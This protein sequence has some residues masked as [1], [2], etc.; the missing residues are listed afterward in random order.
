[1]E[2]VSVLSTMKRELYDENI[3]YN[4]MITNAKYY[5]QLQPLKEYNNLL[6]KYNSCSKIKKCQQN[7]ESNNIIINDINTQL[8]KL[9]SHIWETDFIE[10]DIESSPVQIVTCRTCMMNLSDSK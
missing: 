7:I 3:N 9:C 10:I 6:Q 4:Y 1:M 2:Q 8:N 5:H